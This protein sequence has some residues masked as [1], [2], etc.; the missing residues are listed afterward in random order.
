MD[1]QEEL[2]EFS[3]LLSNLLPNFT[4]YMLHGSGFLYGE[5]RAEHRI[6]SLVCA[7]LDG[8]RRACWTNML[9]GRL[10]ITSAA[11]LSLHL[12]LSMN[13]SLLW[14]GSACWWWLWRSD[15]LDSIEKM[16]C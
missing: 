13:A 14:S 12:R 1:T 2:R 16:F 15:G 4:I 9:K 8:K 10:Q 6:W 5:Q 7:W 3:A 11:A